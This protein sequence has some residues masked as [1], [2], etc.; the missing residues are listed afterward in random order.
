LISQGTT[1]IFRIFNFYV[2][3]NY[4]RKFLVYLFDRS[5]SWVFKTQLIWLVWFSSLLIKQ[6]LFKLTLQAQPVF[7]FVIK[8]GYSIDSKLVKLSA[9]I[10][11]LRLFNW[12]KTH[13]AL[14]CHKLSKLC[15][16]GETTP[17]LTAEKQFVS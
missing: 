15:H 6:D 3:I 2:E 4:V 10:I 12:L 5:F 7:P 16:L 9:A 11:K 17:M 13:K 14:S 1:T 8:R